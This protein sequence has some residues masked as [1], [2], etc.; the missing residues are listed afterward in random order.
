MSLNLEIFTN[1]NSA[2]VKARRKRKYGKKKYPSA[3]MD[4]TELA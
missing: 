4:L 3:F 1:L 2:A